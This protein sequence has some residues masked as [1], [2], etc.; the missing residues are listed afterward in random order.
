VR[1]AVIGTGAMGETLARHLAQRGHQVSISNSRGPSSLGALAAEIG[2][3]ALS[4]ADAARAGDI[5]ILA[6]P[7][8][9]VAELA[10]D[11]F[12]GVPA[13]VV[14]VDIGNYH[15]ELRDGHIAAID[16][17]QPDSEWVAQQI[18]RPVIKA[19]N[20]IFAASLREK[21][22]PKGAQGRVA[23]PVAGDPAAGKAVV[24]RLVDEFGFEP[25]DAGGLDDSWRQQ[26]GTPAYCKDLDAAALRRALAEAEHR[27]VAQYRAEQEARI[28]SEMAA[29]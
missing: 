24:M 27:L 25:V 22:A 3:T 28:R 19:F 5:V 16:A 23:L 11:V 4:V 1:I 21:G 8:K 12:A 10:H 2:A 18:G 6:I 17:G 15:P 26:P 20:S 7:T 14:V 13:H 29:R 9:S